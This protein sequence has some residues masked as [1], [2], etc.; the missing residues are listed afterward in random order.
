MKATVV[1]TAAVWLLSLGRRW[2]TGDWWSVKW[3]F[4]RPHVDRRMQML[5]GG[6]TA[7]VDIAVL[8]GR[9]RTSRV[10]SHDKWTPCWTLNDG[11]INARDG[12]SPGFFDEWKMSCYGTFPSFWMKL[13]WE[14]FSVYEKGEYHLGEST[15]IMNR[16]SICNEASVTC[17]RLQKYWL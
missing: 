3:C 8:S 15:M 10:T 4:I 16:V 9:W 5:G 13:Y 11:S 6:H 17:S 1:V 12:W 14:R 2:F 7:A